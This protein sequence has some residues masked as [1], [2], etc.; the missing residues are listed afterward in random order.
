LLIDG[1]GLNPRDD[2]R[3]YGNG[4][5]AIPAPQHRFLEPAGKAGNLRQWRGIA[6]RQTNLEI[7]KCPKI[8]TILIHST[9][10]HVD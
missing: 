3:L 6:I 9:P 1:C 2:I 10:A 4:R 5:L 8:A 7:P